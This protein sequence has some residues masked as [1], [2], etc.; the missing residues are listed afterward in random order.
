LSYRND[1]YPQLWLTEERIP[2]T[3]A[4]ISMV[5]RTLQERAGIKEQIQDRTHIFRRSWAW[6]QVKAGIPEKYILLAGG[7]ESRAM[8]DRY[9]GAA[10]SEDTIEANW[11]E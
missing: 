10:S 2:A 9:I 4:M 6:E 3:S 11:K 7:W 5:L 1:Q 8:L